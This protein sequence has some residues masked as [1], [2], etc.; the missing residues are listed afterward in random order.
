MSL[1]VDGRSALG[2]PREVGSAVVGGTGKGNRL[3]PCCN[4]NGVVGDG[5]KELGEDGPPGC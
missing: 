5:G 1:R 4:P 3:L 2:D